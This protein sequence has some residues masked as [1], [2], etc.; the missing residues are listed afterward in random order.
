MVGEWSLK[1]AEL[2]ADTAGAWGVC[3]PAM[4]DWDGIYKTRG[5]VQIQV[6]PR[7][8]RIVPFLKQNKVRKILDLGCGTGR[9][10][11]FLAQHGFNVTAIDISDAALG[12]LRNCTGG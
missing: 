4:K 9:H 3:Q 12:Y 5:E 8:R 10:T 11:V 7:V 2:W 1:K 6:L